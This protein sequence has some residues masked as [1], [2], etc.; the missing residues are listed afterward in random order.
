MDKKGSIVYTWV[1]EID[2]SSNKVRTN[3]GLV[4]WI[5]WVSLRCYVDGNVDL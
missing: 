5:L 4:F 3:I 1:K 2:D